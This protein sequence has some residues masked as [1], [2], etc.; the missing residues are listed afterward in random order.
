MAAPEQQTAAQQ[1][2]LHDSLRRAS[3]ATVLRRQW[4]GGLLMNKGVQGLLP[5]V[6]DVTG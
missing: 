2:R 5:S 6:V 4:E 1:H 3:I